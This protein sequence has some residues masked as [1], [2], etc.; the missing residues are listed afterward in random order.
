MYPGG[1]RERSP[2]EVRVPS[3]AL[4]DVYGAWAGIR[5]STRDG[6]GH[7]TRP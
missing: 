1:E 6:C 4:Q 3:G 2:Q 7:Q 5:H